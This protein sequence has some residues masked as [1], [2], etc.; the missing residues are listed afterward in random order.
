MADRTGGD[1][2]ERLGDARRLPEEM[3]R[4]FEGDELESLFADMLPGNF[5]G[6]RA[7]D[8][9]GA[10]QPGPVLG[11]SRQDEARVPSLL[12]HHRSTIIS[13]NNMARSRQGS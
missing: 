2:L 5:Q 12:P 7:A 3:T 9:A 1:P 8:L 11:Q 6:G 13:P 10:V 4:T